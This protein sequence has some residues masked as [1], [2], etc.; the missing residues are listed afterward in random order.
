MKVGDLVKLKRPLSD[1]GKIGIIVGPNLKWLFD[2]KIQV[3][4]P[5]SIQEIHWTNL[6]VVNETR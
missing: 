1:H 4:F 2:L 5:D 6:S 3:M